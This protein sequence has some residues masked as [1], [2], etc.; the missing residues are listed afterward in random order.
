[1]DVEGQK[2][3]ESWRNF[4]IKIAGDYSAGEF[5][6]GDRIKAVFGNWQIEFEILT[7]INAA[8]KPISYS[9][10][11]K[12]SADFKPL[13]DFRFSI[14]RKGFFSNIAKVFGAQ[15][16]V[17]GYP[18][19]DDAFIIK[20]ND[21]NKAQMVFAPDNVRHLISAQKKIYLSI[22]DKTDP[23][24]KKVADGKAELLFVSSEIIKDEN[25]LESLYYLFG[26]MLDQLA[27][28]GSA[29]H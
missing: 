14:H 21:I 28:T 22:I 27:K 2:N 8:A 17:I 23:F 18:E 6:K 10:F 9:C 20:A 4:A 29:A 19:F 12:V 3:I 26:L 15:D 24:G 16:V 13:D 25:I 7:L 11:T 5:N 1:M